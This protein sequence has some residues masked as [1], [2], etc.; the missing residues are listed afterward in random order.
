[1]KNC[2]TYI[3]TLPDF[4]EIQRKSFCW[5]LAQGLSDE[6][7]NFDTIVDLSDNLEICFFKHE[8]RLIQH[9]IQVVSKLVYQLHVQFRH[10]LK[11]KEE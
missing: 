8:Y 1:M 7:N 2:K 10:M 11:K 6:F 4:V 3:T 5:F 9:Q